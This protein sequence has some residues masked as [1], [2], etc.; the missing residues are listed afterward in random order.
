[1]LIQLRHRQQPIIWQAS[2]GYL[3]LFVR[4]RQMRLE[5]KQFNPV[6]NQVRLI[7]KQHLY[8]L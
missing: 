6:E 4:Q 5:I 1:M 8:L 3:W 7:W 2:L